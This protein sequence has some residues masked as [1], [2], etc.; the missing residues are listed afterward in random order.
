MTKGRVT[1]SR[2]STT[3][4]AATA[5]VAMRGAFR[6]FSYERSAGIGCCRRTGQEAVLSGTVT[7]EQG[8]VL[9]GVTVTLVSSIPLYSEGMSEALLH[10]QGLALVLVAEDVGR[11]MDPAI[12][13]TDV[14][15]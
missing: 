5:S 14:G 2:A 8:G 15:P 13:H 11:L 10:R 7:D 1:K 6:T 12:P 3:A 9:P 4:R